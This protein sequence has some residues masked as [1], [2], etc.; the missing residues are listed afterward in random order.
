M[1][2]KNLPDLNLDYYKPLGNPSKFFQELL[3][4]FSRLKDENIT[5][6]E[7]LEYAQGLMQ[8]EDGM[9]SGELAVKL[10]AKIKNQE[11]KNKKIPNSKLQIPN[12][13]LASEVGDDGKQAGAVETVRINELA[14]AYHAYNRLLIAENAL[15]FGDLIVKTIELFRKRPNILAKYRRQFKY[16]MV[17]EF[18]DTNWA[19][20]ELIK[21]LSAPDNN[22]AVVGDDDQC[23]PGG[24]KVLARKGPVKIEKIK[25]GETVL[26]AAGRGHLT[27]S[28]IVHVNKVDK[29]SRFLTFETESG[30]KLTTTDNHKIFCFVP[31]SVNHYS[32][33]GYAKNKFHYVYLMHKQGLGWRIGITNDLAVRLKLERSADR[34]V[35]L[36]SFTDPEEARFRETLLSLKYG[37]PTVC[38]KER[39]GI[40]DKH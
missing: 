31:A 22:L 33:K 23:L 35:A 24:C 2:K 16:I 30:K 12:N 29:K 11:T 5:P 19:Q 18:Q 28:R 13:A 8:D 21:L 1:L 10:S 32:G 34:L 40:L 14:N 20:Y 25:P 9:M 7:Y 37:I 39:D 15:D 36:E 17:D 3:K 27:Y 26:S 38:F 4:H 6:A